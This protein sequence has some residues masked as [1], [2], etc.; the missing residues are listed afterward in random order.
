M[1]CNAVLVRPGQAR[2]AALGDVEV[3]KPGPGEVLAR[4]VRVGICG[5]DA[6]I[7]RGE[8]GE[9]PPGASQLV[10]GHE[11]LLRIE[12]TG[13]LAVGIVRRPCPELCPNCAAGRWDMCTTGDYAEHGIR[14]LDGFLRERLVIPADG[15]VRVPGALEPVAVLVEPLSIV[16]KA[17]AEAWAIQARLKWTP[18]RALVTGAGPVGLLAAYALR[19]R[20]LEVWV[21]DQRP[22]GSPKALAATAVGAHYVDDIE[23]AGSGFDL[24]VEATGYAPLL[25]RASSL[26][27]RNAVLALTGVTSG[28]HEVSVDANAL[29]ADMVL[30]NQVIFGSVNAARAHYEQAVADIGDWVKRWPGATE[31]LIT[32]RHPLA[33]F[34][35]ALGKS[36]DDI[37][38]VVEVGG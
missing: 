3:G 35:A 33:D 1:S 23:Q 18:T 10:L 28:H 32:A 5:T 34:R 30:E 8:Y 9:A 16:E 20:G 12:G 6:E 4:T 31:R 38:T 25:F 17:I 7:D 24:A 21:V 37:K 26:L 27:A 13:E 14:R 11:S 36:P 29:N 2:S 19:Q 15:L 22:A